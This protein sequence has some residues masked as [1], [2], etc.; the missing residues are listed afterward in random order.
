MS[1]SKIILGTTAGLAISGILGIL[2]APEKGSVTRKQILD[3]GCD[4]ADD[5][6]SKFSDLAASITDKIQSTKEF[7]QDLTQE[8]KTKF[9][10]AKNDVNSSSSNY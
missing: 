3:K 9:D 8:A 2:F 6:K 5:L 1:T 7:A 4:Y 10:D